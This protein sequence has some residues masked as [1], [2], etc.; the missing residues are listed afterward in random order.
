MAALRR[1]RI[2]APM[3]YSATLSP[4]SACTGQTYSMAYRLIHEHHWRPCC[5]P[6]CVKDG[7]WA[8][9]TTGAGSTWAPPNVWNS[10]TPNFPTRTDGG[11]AATEEPPQDAR[12]N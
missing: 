11:A 3:A 9:A 7:C 5:A 4:A 8:S 2:S 12:H 10:S 1:Y 6:P